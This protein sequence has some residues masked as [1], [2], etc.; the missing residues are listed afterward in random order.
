MMN[1]EYPRI[2]RY[3]FTLIEVV[4]A[5]AIL[6]ILSVLLFS[7]TRVSIRRLDVLNRTFNTDFNHR[8]VIKTVRNVLTETQPLMQRLGERRILLFSGRRDSMQAV[9]P[10]PSHRGGP[11][12]YTITIG[13]GSGN[14]R[15]DV[16]MRYE[17]HIGGSPSRA[18]S[19]TLFADTRIS[20][21]YFGLMQD[22]NALAWVGSWEAQRKLPKLIE[23]SLT[24]ETDRHGGETHTVPLRLEFGPG[25]P[26]WTIGD[27]T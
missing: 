22:Q 11:G 7:S 3:G 12:L 20:F 10:L 19:V 8:L 27:G 25:Q 1:P 14:H 26:Q 6:S 9:V 24:N 5:L 2:D 4:I 18:E 15:G 16:V 17:P 13:A 23:F 21:R